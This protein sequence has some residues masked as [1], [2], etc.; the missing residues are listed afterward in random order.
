MQIER[1]DLEV[2][3]FY[4]IRGV[5]LYSDRRDLIR[6]TG[7]ICRALDFPIVACH[8]RPAHI[9][10]RNCRTPVH[11]DE[12]LIREHNGAAVR[13]RRSREISTRLKQDG[14]WGATRSVARG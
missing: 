7:P 4:I 11:N 8:V 5:G 12:T 9:P 6:Q 13:D 2:A 3:N 1:A 14:D 10:A